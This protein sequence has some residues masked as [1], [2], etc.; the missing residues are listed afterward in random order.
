V[1]YSAHEISPAEKPI[2]VSQIQ[3]PVG[4]EH[5]PSTFGIGGLLLCYL[6]MMIVFGSVH[7]VHKHFFGVKNLVEYGLY[8]STLSSLLTVFI[9]LWYRPALFA[10]SRWRPRLIDFAISVPLGIFIAVTEMWLV[11]G[12]RDQLGPTYSMEHAFFPVVILAPVAEEILFR[13]IFLRSL[14]ERERHVLAILIVSLFAATA[15]Q[16]FWLALSSQLALSILYVALGDSLAASIILHVTLNA[17][18]LIPTVR[19]FTLR[20]YPFFN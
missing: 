2:S 11:S 13:G 19:S 6:L 9:L 12:M 16:W 17:T 7:T 3:E 1:A 4:S 10:L 8:D 14:R 20:G 15:H 18:M 5:R